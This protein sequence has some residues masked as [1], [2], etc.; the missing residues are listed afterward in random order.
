MHHKAV[1][2]AIDV[3]SR[4]R[5]E[6]DGHISHGGVEF[7]ARTGTAVLAQYLCSQVISV[8]ES[9]QVVLSHVETANR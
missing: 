9:Q 5:L 1:V 2:V 3:G 4:V 6:L 8:V 7:E